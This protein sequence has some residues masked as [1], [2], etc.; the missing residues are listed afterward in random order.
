M[1]SALAAHRRCGWWSSDRTCLP[2]TTPEHLRLQRLPDRPAAQGEPS[3]F[4]QDETSS[5]GAEGAFSLPAMVRSVG[6]RGSHTPAELVDS[7]VFGSDRISIALTGTSSRLSPRRSANP[8]ARA[9]AIVMSRFHQ[10]N[11]SA[12]QRQTDRNSDDDARDPL[13]RAAQGLVEAHLYD[14]EYRQRREHRPSAAGQR[15]RRYVRQHG[16]RCQPGR[17]WPRQVLCV[18]APRRACGAGRPTTRPKALARRRGGPAMGL[19]RLTSRWSILLKALCSPFPHGGPR[20]RRSARNGAARGRSA[21]PGNPPC[22]GGRVCQVWRSSYGSCSLGALIAALRTQ[23]T[24]FR[25]QVQHL[26][27]SRP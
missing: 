7:A 12:G 6:P 19:V 21:R 13:D 20:A 17:W 2:C 3:S 27:P 8:I 15:Q 9:A 18:P 22:L 11:P 10:V 1:A 25:T 24:P 23:W 16:R 14:Q 26:Q 5:R 4:P